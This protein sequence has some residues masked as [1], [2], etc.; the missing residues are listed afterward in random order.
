M[1]LSI[2]WVAIFAAAASGIYSLYRRV[3]YAYLIRKRA[4][5]YAS[6]SLDLSSLTS[7]NDVRVLHYMNIERRA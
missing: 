7:H 1:E 3:R 5:R 2:F 6:A 4:R